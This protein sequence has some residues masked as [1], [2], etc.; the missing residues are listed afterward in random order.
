MV[1]VCR[2]LWAQS[3]FA[4]HFRAGS[5][6]K[7]PCSKQNQINAKFGAFTAFYAQRR[8]CHGTADNLRQRAL[9][10]A[11]WA[12]IHAYFAA[13]NRSKIARSPKIGPGNTPGTTVPP[14]GKPCRGRRKDSRT[15]TEFPQTSEGNSCPGI[16]E[17]KSNL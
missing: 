16:F 14:Y 7:E 1:P 9:Q 12:L 13:Q 17:L 3:H 11:F 2:M 8:V 6:S 5:G 10:G 15:P 4:L